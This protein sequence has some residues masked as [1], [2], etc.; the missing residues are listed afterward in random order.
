MI[1]VNGLVELMCI[2]LCT[3]NQSLFNL[4]K[5]LVETFCKLLHQYEELQFIVLDIE[6]LLGS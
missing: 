6:S 2:Q 3:I 4:G 5:L 1:K